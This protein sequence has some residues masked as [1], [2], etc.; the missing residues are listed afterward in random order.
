MGI[1]KD[2]DWN[3]D[4]WLSVPSRSTVVSSYIVYVCVCVH[5]IVESFGMQACSITDGAKAGKG[6]VQL[7]NVYN[8][9]DSGCIEQ[10]HIVTHS[11]LQSYPD[12]S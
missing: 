6:G 7:A 2:S 10:P 12:P 3:R 1:N 8:L 9:Y 5:L 11:L 4:D